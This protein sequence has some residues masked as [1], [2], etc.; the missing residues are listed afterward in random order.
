MQKSSIYIY[1][2]MRLIMKRKNNYILL[3]FNIVK[4][5]HNIIF[6]K[7]IIP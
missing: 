2:N 5:Y 3:Y 6:Y 4:E 7:T 1:K